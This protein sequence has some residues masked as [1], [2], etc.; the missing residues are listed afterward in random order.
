MITYGNYNYDSSL[1]NSTSVPLKLSEL[2]S[3]KLSQSNSQLQKASLSPQN[4][5]C[6][7]SPTNLSVNSGEDMSIYNTSLYVYWNLT[8][9]RDVITYFAT[10]NS[11]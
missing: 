5:N 10:T 1:S 7:F 3:L 4:S 8:I 2:H 6:I 11:C 9:S